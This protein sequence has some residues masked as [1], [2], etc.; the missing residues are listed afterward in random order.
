V[1]FAFW[2]PEDALQ[3]LDDL[4][5]DAAKLCGGR[6]MQRDSLHMTLAFIGSVSPSQ[7][8]DLRE[9]AS[10]IEGE[11]FD[12]QVDRMGYWPHNRIVWAGCSRVSSRQRR[13]FDVLTVQLAE[14]GFVLDGHPFV[15]HVTL[16]RNARCGN[17]PELAHPI[18]W[19]VSEFVLV[20]S[21][22]QSSGARYRLLD[23]WPLKSTPDKK[24]S[25]GC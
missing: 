9:I 20:E 1:F 4:A 8:A 22:L 10:R 5:I 7:L 21:R 25:K 14:A 6:R 17:L 2:P 3:A 19:P 23:C 15:P 13:L 12:L 24:N 16:L 18:Y 11:V